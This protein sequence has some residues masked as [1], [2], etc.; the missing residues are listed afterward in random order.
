[1]VVQWSAP[2]PPNNKILAS[3]TWVQ[4]LSCVKFARSLRILW[5]P[6]TDVISKSKPYFKDY[7]LYVV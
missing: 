6:P 1:M 4:R 3:V 5:L 7:L 2:L